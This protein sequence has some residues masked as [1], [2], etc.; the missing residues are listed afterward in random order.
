MGCPTP[1]RVRLIPVTVIGVPSSGTRLAARLLDASPDLDVWHDST[2]GL[3][4]KPGQV[5]IVVRDEPARRRSELARWPDGY[6]DRIDLPALARRYDPTVILAYEAIVADP[7][8]V[9]ACAARVF[10]V[11][12]WTFTEPTYD[13][14][15]EPGSRCGP[16]ME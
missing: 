6:P 3:N 7:A 10:D 9:I 14:N 13:G 15:A 1:R 5:V 2:H 4:P 8:D 11:P 12:P 16:L